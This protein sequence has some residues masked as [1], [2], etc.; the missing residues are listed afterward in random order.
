MT[1][2]DM[3][4]TEEREGERAWPHVKF[5]RCD[6]RPHFD[7]DLVNLSAI[8]Q[9][10]STEDDTVKL[11]ELRASE[12]A[13]WVLI[14]HPKQIRQ[15]ANAHGIKLTDNIEIINPKEL[16]P[17]YV[18]FLVELRKHKGMTKEIAAEQ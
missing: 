10:E 3:I 13:R 17:K 11:V 15:V 18:D 5:Y 12:I 2:K 8:I 4:V 6:F 7:G 16:I 1:H 9:P 14:G